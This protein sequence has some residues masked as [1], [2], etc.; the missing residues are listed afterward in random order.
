VYSQSLLIGE[1][2]YAVDRNGVPA[3]G[4]ETHEERI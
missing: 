4:A 2:I 3:T 1:G